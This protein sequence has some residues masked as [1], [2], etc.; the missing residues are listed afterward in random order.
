[1]I[2]S[3]HRR[4]NYFYPP[5]TWVWSDCFITYSG[6]WRYSFH[7]QTRISAK[8]LTRLRSPSMGKQQC[9]LLTPPRHPPSFSPFSNEQNNP[10]PG[11]DFTGNGP[12]QQCWYNH[13]HSRLSQEQAARGEEHLGQLCHQHSHGCV[14]L[15][16]SLKP[17]VW[18]SSLSKNLLYKPGFY[19]PYSLIHI[20]SF[21]DNF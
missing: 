9:H 1:M 11:T 10:R 5:S 12:G 13:R 20:Y 21:Q 18:G 3:Q 15:Q 7:L 16:I 2:C 4:V 14:S 8:I 17:E 19:L 6:T